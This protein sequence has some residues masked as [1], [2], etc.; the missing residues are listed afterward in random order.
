MAL[1]RLRDLPSSCRHSPLGRHRDE[2]SAKP[3]APS[4]LAPRLA[5][6]ATAVGFRE[7]GQGR[8]VDSA[9]LG[10]RPSV[11]AQRVFLKFYL[12]SV[13]RLNEALW[14][15]TPHLF[16]PVQYHPP[17]LPQV[18]LSRRVP[19]ALLEQGPRRSAKKRRALPGPRTTGRKTPKAK[20]PSPAPGG[21]C[22]AQSALP[23]PSLAQP[24]VLPALL[25]MPAGAQAMALLLP[26]PWAARC[27][28]QG[29]C[30]LNPLGVSATRFCS[31]VA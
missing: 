19:A 27:W 20:A 26:Q 15:Q 17:P 4:A 3:P 22:C 21:T 12:I 1:L 13:S 16:P 5:T 8:R 7:A 28:R 29:L 31:G 11:P 14:I 6:L 30:C 23:R 25:L 9:C 2:Q 10:P 24:E 18:I